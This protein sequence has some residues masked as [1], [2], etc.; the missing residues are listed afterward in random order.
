[1]SGPAEGMQWHPRKVMGVANQV[2]ID[3]GRR[4]LGAVAQNH[5]TWACYL[6]WP[7]WH[8]LGDAETLAAGMALVEGELRSCLDAADAAY[9][10]DTRKGVSLAEHGMAIL[11]AHRMPRKE[12]TQTMQRM[13]N[14]L[15]RPR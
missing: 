14:L 4:W 11:G 9:R 2:L 5:D 15:A 12:F 8:R 13:S 7:L 1:M 3:E 6:Y 10:L